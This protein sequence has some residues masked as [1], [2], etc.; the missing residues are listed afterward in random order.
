MGLCLSI[1]IEDEPI[2]KRFRQVEVNPD[3]GCEECKREGLE[4]YFHQVKPYG[5]STK[6]RRNAIVI[7]IRCARG[8]EQVTKIERTKEQKKVVS[9]QWIASVKPV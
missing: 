5:V 6:T 4:V 7:P 9:K 8:H 1:P 2:P 3:G